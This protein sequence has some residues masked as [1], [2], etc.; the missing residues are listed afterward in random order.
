MGWSIVLTL[1]AQKGGSMHIQD[2]A[3]TGPDNVANVL[4]L[5]WLSQVFGILGVAAGKISVAALLLAIIQLTEL[6]WQ[7]IFLWIVPVTL[8]SLVAISCS[9]LTFAQCT[10]AKALWDQR[11]TGKCID[12]HVMSSFGTFTG[13]M[14]AFFS[15]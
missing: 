3:K 4:F 2:V 13:G 10:P 11:V 1:Y 14:S 7:R 12:P 15:A 5:N 8:A 6:R 9:T